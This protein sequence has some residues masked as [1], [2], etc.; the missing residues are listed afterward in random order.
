M[1]GNGA[2]STTPTVGDIS[3][4]TL[5]AIVDPG[6]SPISAGVLITNTF[7]LTNS[8]RLAIQIGGTFAGGNGIDGYDRI[9][10]LNPTASAS[11]SGGFLDL[12]DVAISA[13]PA[14][15]LLFIVVNNGTGAPSGLFS[16]VTLGGSPVANIN[17]IVIGGQQFA[18][19][20]NANFDGASGLYGGFATGGNDIALV[21]VP[22]PLSV[23]TL[24]CGATVLALRRR[25]RD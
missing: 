15:A 11:V 16:G 4:V 9:N 14:D 23:A 3:A 18:L 6:T 13:L 24:L 17:N 19:V 5:G 7:S 8:A 1:G 22:E 25:R 2:V 20:N 21:A 12:A 10:V